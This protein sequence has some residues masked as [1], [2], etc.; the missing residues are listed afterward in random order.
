MGPSISGA[1]H[2]AVSPSS[3]APS[4]PH[5][6]QDA[7]PGLGDPQRILV[8]TLCKKILKQICEPVARRICAPPVDRKGLPRHRVQGLLFC[9][10]PV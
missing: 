9:L 5:L 1:A 8:H 6:A 4:G 10:T 7:L 3:E 2:E